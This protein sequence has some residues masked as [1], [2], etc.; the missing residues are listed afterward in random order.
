MTQA[1]KTAWGKTRGYK[2]ASAGVMLLL[3]QLYKLIWPD[4]MSTLWDEWVYN[5]IGVV[6]ATGVIDKAWMHRA[7]IKQL[8]IKLFKKKENGREKGV[9]PAGRGE[10]T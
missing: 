3:F 7:K 1:I 4:A 6:G 5:A 2:T 9:S 10:E 8:F